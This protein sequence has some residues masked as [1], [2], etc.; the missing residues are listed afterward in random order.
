MLRLPTPVPLVALCLTLGLSGCGASAEEQ[1]TED[2]QARLDGVHGGFL[3]R[4]AQ[5]PA[6]TGEAA[7][8]SLD[9]YGY[10]VQTSFHEDSITFVRTIDASAF[11]GG[12]LSYDQVD[13][14]ACLLV[15][16]AYGSGG[17]LG[18]VSTE[19]VT[20]PAGT[21]LPGGRTV[22]LESRSDD[23][24]EWEPGPSRSVCMSGEL[25]TEG[26]G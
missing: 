21:D 4:R 14:G 1:A 5:D 24:E 18:S 23:V 16:V 6:P 20:C 10:S 22:E 19:P 9:R 11:T 15:T 3:E 2:L 17:D 13:L 25:C 8:Q 7:Q 26:G 12:G